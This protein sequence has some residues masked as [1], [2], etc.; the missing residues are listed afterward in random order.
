MAKT[1][2]LVKL[3][4]HSTF[5]FG[6]E[7]TFGGKD[8]TGANYLVKSNYWP[9]QTG[10]LGLI[11]HQLL[12]QNKLLTDNKINNKE[13]A[14]QLIG[15]ESFKVGNTFKFGA[16]QSISPVYIASDKED[17]LFPANKQYQWDEQ[18][19]RFVHRHYEQKY[20]DNAYLAGYNAKEG[21]PDLLLSQDLQTIRFYDFDEDKAQDEQQKKSNGIFIAQEQVGIKKNYQ[22]NTE[23]NAFYVQTFYKLQKGYAFAFVV[24]LSNEIEYSSG[25]KIKPEFESRDMVIFGGEKSAFNME[26]KEVEKDYDEF[27]PNYKAEKK[28][29][30]AVLLSDA[31]IAADIDKKWDFAIV[32]SVDFRCLHTHVQRTVHYAQLS[33]KNPKAI[34][35][36]QKFNLYKKGSVFFGEGVELKQAFENPLFEKVGYNKIKLIHKK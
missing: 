18:S 8:G 11:R 7:S 25:E 9:Q 32:E 31:Y 20:D 14:A 4:P 35:K 19:K 34:T 23:D 6:G 21:L 12:I 22:G 16:I 13:S 27:V 2:Y 3:T 5:F 17:Y 1:K 30:K 28:Y 33:E 29:D 24:E 36:S 15:E 26:V 10:I